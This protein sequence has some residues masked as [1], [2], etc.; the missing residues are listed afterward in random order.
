MLTRKRALPGRKYDESHEPWRSR[1]SVRRR[2]LLIRFSAKISVWN[3]VRFSIAGSTGTGTSSPAASTCSGRS[4]VMLRSDTLS[5]DSSITPS[6]SSISDFRMAAP[7][8][9]SSSGGVFSIAL[10]FD[11]SLHLS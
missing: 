10:N 1:C 7:Y 9:F 6:R 11:L 4:H 8:W 2:S 3:G 5:Y